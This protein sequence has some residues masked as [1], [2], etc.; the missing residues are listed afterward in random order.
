[1]KPLSYLYRIFTVTALT[2]SINIPLRA[3]IVDSDLEVKLKPNTANQLLPVIVSLNTRANLNIIKDKDKKSRHTKT[4]R[5]LLDH[6]NVTQPALLAF[7]RIMGATD[8]KPLWITNSIA[9]KLPANAIRS[10]AKFPGVA[11]VYTDMTLSASVTNI[12]APSTSAW[13]LLAIHAPELWNLGKTGQGV[14]VANIDTG[15]DAIHPDLA[16][17]WRGGNNSW[18]DPHG[19]YSAPTDYAGAASGHGTQTMGLIVGSGV[20]AIGAAPGAKWIAAK[21]FNS[22]G[23]ALESHFHQSFQWMLDP[24]SNPNTDDAPDVVNG[25]FQTAPFGVCD[26]RFQTDIQLLKTAGIAVVFAAGNG[27]SVSASSSS[28]GNNPGSF[29][30]GAID[31]TLNIATFSARGPTPTGCDGMIFPNLVAPGVNVNTTDLSYAGQA[32]YATV[33]GTSFA[34]PHVA[35]GMAILMGAFPN[36]PVTALES[37]LITSASDLGAP[38]PDNNYGYGLLN[39]QGAY[40]IL[41]NNAQNPVGSVDSFLVDED[42]PLTVSAPGVLGND[43]DPQNNPITAVL[44][45]NATH[46]L[47]NLNSNGAFSYTPENNF[48]GVDS[49]TY[50][51]SDGLY[52]SGL[53]TV[54]ITVNPIN[55]APVATTD[56][57]QLNAGGTIA[58]PVLA[59]DSDIESSPL[60]VIIESAPNNGST[61]INPDNAVVYTHNGNSSTADSFTYHVSDGDMNSN[62]VT[63]Y[64]TIAPVGITANPDSY[65]FNEDN[66]LSIATPGVLN[67][68]HPNSGITAQ[69]VSAPAHAASFSLNANGSFS[70]V[71]ISNYSGTDSFAYKNVNA[72]AQSNTASV[73]ININPVNDAPVAVNDSGYTVQL[74]QVLNVSAAAGVLGNDSDAENNSLSAVLVSKPSSGSLVLNAD[75]SFSF[76]SKDVSTGIYTFKYLANDSMPVN[77]Q[78][79]TAIVTVNVVSKN[80]APIAKNDTF[81]YRQSITRIVD[82]KGMLGSGVLKNDTDAQNNALSAQYVANSLS[83][84]GNLNLN[85]DGS[86]SYTKSTAGKSSFRYR[87]SDGNLLSLPTSG[88][89]V[90]LFPDAPPV[91][92]ADECEYD[93][94]KKATDEDNKCKALGNRVI[95]MA[96]TLN[97]SDPN[98]ETNSPSDGIGSAIV[99]N[100]TLVASVG[101]GV[102][103]LANTKCGQLALGASPAV[104]G[105]LTNNCDGTVTVTVASNN[106]AKRID[107]SYR[108]SDDLG[109][110][111]NISAVSLKIQP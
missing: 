31:D 104:R 110:Q 40:N 9:A 98:K 46:G 87:A 96:V 1:M 3:G 70:Y 53:V 79:N 106:N 76:N 99:P 18:Y 57:A 51:V 103:M 91:T 48:N 50:K 92:K 78:S 55:D 59:N 16:P 69:L 56:T 44:V 105:T 90:E 4:L 11:K 23:T 88:T 37:A 66:I 74:G 100:S 108:V 81:L 64:L 33:D 43:S 24:D 13:N 67:N 95:R 42:T 89:T 6:A 10:L 58:I 5:A 94:S 60:T 61:S 83:G 45:N 26:N 39:V 15:V 84:G 63:V 35:A 77:N 85:L 22:Q 75:G 73:S 38:G 47:V 72:T 36:L 68:D 102:N 62:T 82:L 27:G 86:F 93:I 107:Y 41:A 21:V 17:S 8:I 19:Q 101:T 32:T 34:A 25:S 28:P 52:Q 49:F 14:V 54:A 111:S 80:T 29:A 12:A 30:A 109:A 7:L 65:S 20:N 2:F 97:D 71:P